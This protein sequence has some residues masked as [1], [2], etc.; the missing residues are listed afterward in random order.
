MSGMES[1]VSVANWFIERGLADGQKGMCPIR[2]Q[3]LVYLAYGWHLALT[4][5]PLTREVPLAMW[6]GP[7]FPQLLELISGFFTV[8]DPIR[9]VLTKGEVSANLEAFLERI[10]QV[11]YR[12]SSAQLSALVSSEDSPWMKILRTN[13]GRVNLQIPDAY[14]L[15]Y[16]RGKLKP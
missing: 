7:C 16:Y 8:D 15:D 10:W 3:K 5:K 1:S 13:P 14:I 4:G 2:V 9:G 11:Y 6:W 12:L